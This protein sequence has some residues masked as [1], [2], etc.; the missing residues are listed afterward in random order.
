MPRIV[1][2]KEIDGELWARIGRPGDFKD[3]VSLWTQG[4]KEAHRVNTLQDVELAISKLL[5]D[6]K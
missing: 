5:Y 4:E 3:G 2:L 6:K 1:E